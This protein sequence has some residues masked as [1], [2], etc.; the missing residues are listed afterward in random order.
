MHKPLGGIRDTKRAH[1]FGKGK[2]AHAE[3]ARRFINTRYGTERA[4]YGARKNDFSVR[5]RKFIYGSVYKNVSPFSVCVIKIFGRINEFITFP[6]CG[7][8]QFI[9]IR[10]SVHGCADLFVHKRYQVAVFCGGL[11]ILLLQFGITGLQQRREFIA[12]TLPQLSFYRRLSGSS[13]RIECIVTCCRVVLR[14]HPCVLYEQCFQGGRIR[15]VFQ[16][17]NGCFKRGD[18]LFD[19][20]RRDLRFFR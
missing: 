4:G 12:R 3:S 2:P 5:R 8:G 16:S 13:H 14:I 19:L 15:N 6:A 20:V 17:G 9:R 1:A 18:R 10:F 11:K 7:N